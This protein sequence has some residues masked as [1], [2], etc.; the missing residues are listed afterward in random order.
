MEKVPRP[1]SVGGKQGRSHLCRVERLQTSRDIEQ[2]QG[3]EHN[4]KDVKTS[5]LLS[6]DNRAAR[7]GG[8]LVK[9]RSAIGAGGVHPLVLRRK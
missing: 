7:H 3:R 1:A 5:Y 8:E 4:D 2:Q 6:Q 9:V